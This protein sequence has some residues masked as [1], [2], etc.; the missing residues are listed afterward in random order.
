[1]SMIRTPQLTP[2]V[3]ELCS[4]LN[5]SAQP[6]FTRITPESDAQPNDCFHSVQRKLTAEGREQLKELLRTQDQRGIRRG[7]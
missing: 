5:P 1:M 6:V 7:A 2:K 3:L 4:R